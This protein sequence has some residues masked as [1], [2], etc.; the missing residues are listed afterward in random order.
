VSTALPQANGTDTETTA[1]AYSLG[2][3][4][5]EQY[6]IAERC[7]EDHVTHVIECGRLLKKQRDRLNHGE[8]QPW[9]AEHCPQIAERTARH[10]MQAAEAAAVLAE[11]GKPCR[12]ASI[13]ALLDAAA[14]AQFEPPNNDDGHVE[15]DRLGGADDVH[16]DDDGYDAHQENVHEDDVRDRARRRRG[17]RRWQRFQNHYSRITAVNDGVELFMANFRLLVQALHPDRAP[18]DRREQFE[19]ATAAL[20]QIRDTFA[21]ASEEAAA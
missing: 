7:A 2:D 4:I 15:G 16:R 19:R 6:E 9:L 20:T 17:D 21:N 8:W 5:N 12:F 18:A 10:Y 1:Y 13:A 11:N 14:R 3:L